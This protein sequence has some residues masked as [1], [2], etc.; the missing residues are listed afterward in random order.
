MLSRSLSFLAITISATSLMADVALGQNLSPYGTTP[1]LAEVATPQ[2]YSLVHVNAASGSDTAGDGTQL[3]PYQTIS[4]ALEVASPNSIVLLAP[5]E[6]SE[7]SGEEFPLQLRSG[8]TVQGAPNPAAGQTVIRG[9]GIYQSLTDGYLQA[10][11]LGVDGA[12]LGHVVVTNP[13]SNGYGLV[14]EAGS[15]V[16]RGNAFIGSGYG[17]AYVA[18][19]GSPIIEN[20]LFRQ[21]GVVGLVI[22]G[23]STASVQGNVFENTGTGIR[24]AP[25]A[26]PQIANNR[27]TQNRDGIV[28]DANARPT[29]GNNVI[30]GNRRNGVVEFA[31][32][33]KEGAATPPAPVFGQGGANPVSFAAEPVN[34]FPVPS[35]NLGDASLT[36]PPTATEQ[37]SLSAPPA[38][39]VTPQ[40]APSVS[41][42]PTV[43]ESAAQNVNLAATAPRSTVAEPIN[44]PPPSAGA[45][46]N[47]GITPDVAT[48]PT[49]RSSV[50]AAPV[51]VESGV[52][53]SPPPATQNS[54][55]TT[56]GDN[57]SAS[58][59]AVSA[60]V[61][62]ASS[63]P[64]T[65]SIEGR[66]A[67]S[68]EERQAAVE[69]PAVTVIPETV[70]PV[71][72]AEAE[73]G[74]ALSEPS[75]ATLPATPQIDST[76]A[77]EPTPLPNSVP[78]RLAAQ[79]TTAEIAI[80]PSNEDI[81]NGPLPS[82]PVSVQNDGPVE[83]V[84]VEEPAPAVS[85]TAAAS[86]TRPDSHAAT[87]AASSAATSPS[88][89]ER[90]A[91]IRQGL[92]NNQSPQ[93]AQPVQTSDIEAIPLQV[94]P[95]PDTLA[96]AA[97]QSG[98]APSATPEPAESNR[99]IPSENAALATAAPTQ[100][101]N[102][103]DRL[104]VPAGNIPSRSQGEIPDLAAAAPGLQ[105]V[106]AVDAD[107]PPPPPPSLS[108][109]LGLVYKVLVPVTNDATQD[110][111]RSL[112]PDAFRVRFEGQSMIQAG[113]YPDQATAE[114]TA[115]RLAQ[116]GLDARVEY[117]P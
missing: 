14:I 67:T 38:A 43:A 96:M 77:A 93:P 61:S 105:Q 55:R 47:P 19:H 80:L 7:A 73:D 84:Q 100:A 72:P 31:S 13:I 57:P 3:R 63:E 75:S 29:L 83:D 110:Q 60:S 117:M 98:D 25:G 68:I 17:G 65:A 8:V 103:P 52:V 21:N 86:P 37:R 48:A 101:A 5:G 11:I 111:V 44:Q 89:A 16:I 106:V 78:L 107:A 27:V 91:R 30:A 69:T 6:Y 22:A 45:R 35:T 114:A 94:I 76:S 34:P 49:P 23:Q 102:T 15:P 53:S 1:A 64:A 87:G 116:A 108:S 40:T 59:A 50:T 82:L 56:P 28:L 42:P 36:P 26:Q 79:G 92:Q 41:A 20:N 70:E 97:P 58:A 99:A 115:A 90:W 24:V 66:Q 9:S 33:T 113:A 32:A 54:N 88:A 74:I 81:T 46:T 39:G 4:H 95:A 109:M 104:P 112:V 51:A 10:T 62:A 71:A 18:G 85:N 12:G 2:S